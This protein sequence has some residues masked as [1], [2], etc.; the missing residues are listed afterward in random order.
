MVTV[1]MAG[2]AHADR[3]K[4]CVLAS[5][6]SD[7]PPDGAGH[8]EKVEHHEQNGAALLF[9]ALDDCFDV[10]VKAVVAY[11]LVPQQEASNVG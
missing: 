5:M 4:Y 11:H 8:A 1:L 6:A 9:G 2:T 10:A 3:W 7:D